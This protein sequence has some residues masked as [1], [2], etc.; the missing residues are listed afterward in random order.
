MIAD[1]YAENWEKRGVLQIIIVASCE[2]GETVLEISVVRNRLAPNEFRLARIACA[3]GKAHFKLG[4]PNIVE[5]SFHRKAEVTTPPR[6]D[7]SETNGKTRRHL[8]EVNGRGAMERIC[9]AACIV[10]AGQSDRASGGN[11]DCS[12]NPTAISENHQRAHPKTATERKP[13]QIRVARLQ[14]RPD[15]NVGTLV[16]KGALVMKKACSHPNVQSSGNWG[17][18]VNPNS[19]RSNTR[20]YGD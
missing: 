16:L 4:L 15:V 2:R 1:A 5:T 13:I 7:V 11:K 3:S 20:I 8:T 10:S 17:G 18:K 19:I 6:D 12:A 14:F 9:M